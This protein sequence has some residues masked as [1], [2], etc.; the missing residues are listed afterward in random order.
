MVFIFE[1]GGLKDRN[2]KQKRSLEEEKCAIC[3]SIFFLVQ[4]YTEYVARRKRQGCGR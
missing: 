1:L 2:T 3:S 4:T